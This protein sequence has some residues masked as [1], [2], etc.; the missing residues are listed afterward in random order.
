MYIYIASHMYRS[1]G[2]KASLL[3]HLFQETFG[4]L[5]WIQR[6]TENFKERE[7]LITAQDSLS[8]YP[9]DGKVVFSSDTTQCHDDDYNTCLRTE[10]DVSVNQISNQE[11]NNELNEI[12]GDSDGNAE[13]GPE[14]WII[15][16]M[17]VTSKYQL[18]LAYELRK[19]LRK[20]TWNNATEILEL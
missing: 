18:D 5:V 13:E 7:R 15:G 6:E 1:S 8:Q 11:P 3:R 14:R 9:R 12:K 19:Q 2:L 4:Q 17:N 10:T 20:L 16:M